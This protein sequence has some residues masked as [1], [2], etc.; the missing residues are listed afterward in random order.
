MLL[1][2]IIGSFDSSKKTNLEDMEPLDRP[3][4]RVI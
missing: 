2:T 4:V 3:A 1:S